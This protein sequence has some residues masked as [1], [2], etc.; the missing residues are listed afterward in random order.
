MKF[1]NLKRNYK[2]LGI[3]P[4]QLRSNNDNILLELISKIGMEM[5]KFLLC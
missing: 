5:G 4:L 1:G 2:N 3:I